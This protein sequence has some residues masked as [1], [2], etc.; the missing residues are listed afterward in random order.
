VYD[1]AS[2]TTIQVDIKY[3]PDYTE[4]EK[5]GINKFLDDYIREERMELRDI[6]IPTGS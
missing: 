2:Y 6:K 4:E 3:G 1:R 5:K